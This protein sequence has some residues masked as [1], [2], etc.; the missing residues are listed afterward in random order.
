MRSRHKSSS[1]SFRQQDLPRQARSF[2][3]PVTCYDDDATAA[4]DGLLAEK[5]LSSSQD[6]ELRRGK[7]E[8]EEVVDAWLDDERPRNTQVAE[9]S[10]Q[11]TARAFYL[12]QSPHVWV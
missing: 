12:R 9:D 3:L 10:S 2:V 11:T 8:E 6:N 7:R 5:R 1:S 4:S